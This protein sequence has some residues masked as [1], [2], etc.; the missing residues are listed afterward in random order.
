M[1][2]VAW[3]LLLAFAFAVPW[4]YSLDLGPPLGNIARLAGIA[5]VLAVIP[6]VFLAGRVR[7]PGPLQWLVL[8]LFLWFC[9]SCSGP[10]I[11]ARR[12]IIC[13]G[14]FRR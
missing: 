4:E 6:S 12:C 9:C 2:R 7:T 8:G 10:L 11:A 5:V 3:V 13:A 1:R 14:T